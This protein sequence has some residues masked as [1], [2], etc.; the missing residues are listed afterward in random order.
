MEMAEVEHCKATL[1]LLPQISYLASLFGHGTPL[2]YPCTT[3]GSHMQ[4]SFIH[5]VHLDTTFSLPQP[6]SN[7]N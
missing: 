2:S 5:Q 6:S 7:Q 4:E 1:G 3:L